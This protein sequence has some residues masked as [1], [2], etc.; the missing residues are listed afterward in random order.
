MNWQD[1]PFSLVHTTVTKQKQCRALLVWFLPL[2]VA[3][4]FV[5]LP[6][7]AQTTNKQAHIDAVNAEMNDAIQ[8]VQQ[9]ANQLV[10]AYRRKPDM[11]VSVSSPGWFHP[12][13][14]MPDFNNVDVRTSQ[15][16]PYLKST[17]IT[18]DLNPGLVFL[19]RDLEFNSNIKYFYT[20]RSLPKKKLTEAEMLEINRLYRII[21]HC[22]QQLS[23]LQPPEIPPKST[24]ETMLDRFPILIS[25]PARIVLGVV[26]LSGIVYLLRRRPA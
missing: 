21:G 2:P 24:A 7:A 11:E 26:V 3:A 4:L 19:G 20:N 14:N 10:A 1:L 8:Q 22:R 6:A 23:E 9:I 15:Q 13:A 5:A 17:Y 25:T 18:S 16:F 12:G